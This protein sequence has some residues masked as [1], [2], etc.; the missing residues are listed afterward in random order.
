MPRVKSG[1]ISHRRLKKV[2]K[3]AK[4]FY[5]GKHS[6][7]RSANEA[8]MRAGQYAFRDRR[9]RKREF[10]ALWIMR[11][12]TAVRSYGINYS[13]LIFGLNKANIQI[14]RKNMAELAVNDPA[15]FEQLAL[16]AKSQLSA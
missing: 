12:N 8:L 1:I 15:A 3:R 6:L 14:D 7:Y 16:T 13:Q 2:L 10:R 4:G 5:G 11:I 9:V